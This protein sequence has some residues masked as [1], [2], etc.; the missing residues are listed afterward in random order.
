M[1]GTPESLRILHPDTAS[2][3]ASELDEIIT[4]VTQPTSPWISQ[5]ETTAFCRALRGEF[6]ET[7]D[8]YFFLSSVGQRIV[9]HCWYQVSLR[10]RTVG[11]LGYVFTDQSFRGSG[12]CS[13]LMR[14]LWEHFGS[15]GGKAMY[16]GAGNPLVYLKNG[17]SHFNGHVMRRV[18]E[19]SGDSNFDQ[20]HFRTGVQVTI[21][22]AE[23]GDLALATC[24]YTHPFQWVVRDLTENVLLIPY[25]ELS[26]CNSIYIALM[27]RSELVGNSM[28]VM[29]T[30]ESHIVGCASMIGASDGRK[31][32][33]EF[34]AHPDWVDRLD[35]ALSLLIGN[36][37]EIFSFA[38]LQDT[39]KI[40]ILRR[41]GFYECKEYSTQVGGTSQRIK[42][43]VRNRG[44]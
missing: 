41:M 20:R 40:S 23:W 5:N 30:E 27:L 13:R 10:N 17:F 8:D 42:E 19:N 11:V 25:I 35:S 1:I 37:H 32:T 2:L 33:L 14:V 18:I 16:L 38:A 29:E 24:L 43:F 7:S 36:K 39:S 34:L 3:P 44:D 12:H 22:S 6:A 28:V 9:A 21:R 31:T 4:F 15:R 26:R